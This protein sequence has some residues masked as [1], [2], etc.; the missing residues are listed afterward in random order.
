M[1]FLQEFDSA[2]EWWPLWTRLVWPSV[3]LPKLIVWSLYCKDSFMWSE[4]HGCSPAVWLV[5]RCESCLH[6]QQRPEVKTATSLLLWLFWHFHSYYRLPYLWLLAQAQWKSVLKFPLAPQAVYYYLCSLLLLM[7]LQ[8]ATD[9][10]T[11]SQGES[12]YVLMYVIF[13]SICVSEWTQRENTF[14]PA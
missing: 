9:G 5:W 8:S 3:C 13:M 14:F 2:G 11:E 4:D 10:K 12:L 6:P 7:A 1:A